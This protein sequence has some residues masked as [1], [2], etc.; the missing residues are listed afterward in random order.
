MSDFEHVF[1]PGE[2]GWTLVLLH[3]TGGDKNDL[4]PLGRQ[5]LPG[6]AILSP[7]G[8][9]L[10]NG[11]SRRFFKRLAVGELDIPDLLAQTDDLASFLAS[12]AERYSLDPDRLIALG[13]SNG[14][15]I[16]VSLLFRHPGLLN[17]AALLRPMLPY[18]PEAGLDLAGTGVLIAAG[19]RDH[20]VPSSESVNLGKALEASGAEVF[21]HLNPEAGHGLTEGD[22]V[23]T[24]RWL[25]D[26][27]SGA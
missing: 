13:L 6:A 3:G 21:M 23:E 16:A 12:T 17:A 8:K 11:V 14:A 18:E 2:S 10:E 26:R 15:N 25:L 20:Y 4:V 27:T 22:L 24:S 7:D 5:L 19:G 9:V 1:E